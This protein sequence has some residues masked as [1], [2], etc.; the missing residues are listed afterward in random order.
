MIGILNKIDSKLKEE[1]DSVEIITPDNERKFDYRFLIEKNDMKIDF[2]INEKDLPLIERNIFIGEYLSDTNDINSKRIKRKCN[3]INI[4]ETI[5]QIFDKKM[6]SASYVNFA[7]KTKVERHNNR[8]DNYI[9]DLLNEKCKIENIIENNEYIIAKGEISIGH[10]L[11]LESLL[12]GKKDINYLVY[13]GKDELKIYYES[14]DISNEEKTI[15][16]FFFKKFGIKVENF[17][18]EDNQ[19]TGHLNKDDYSLEFKIYVDEPYISIKIDGTHITDTHREDIQDI[20]NSRVTTLDE[21]LNRYYPIFKELMS[22]YSV[23]DN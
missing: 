1:F 14:I 21:F 11:M 8:K 10:A 7:R 23:E 16:D 6:F 18:F 19:Y 15:K 5:N 13:N 9:I 12:M 20:F 2:K 3:F 17:K 4:N 22:E